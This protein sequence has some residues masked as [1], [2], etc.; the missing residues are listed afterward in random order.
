MFHLTKQNDNCAT[1][2]P[3]PDKA[4]PGEDQLTGRRVMRPTTLNSL[5]I[6][7]HDFCCKKPLLGKSLGSWDFEYYLPILLGSVIP[8]KELIFLHCKTWC[9]FLLTCYVHRRAQTILANLTILSP[10]IW[11][12]LCNFFFFKQSH[13]ICILNGVT[14]SLHTFVPTKL[15]SKKWN[16]MP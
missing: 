2:L 9:Q 12:S 3:K 1:I 6:I 14:L 13:V 11:F 16:F 4:M 10:R 5:L 15:F 7:T 8:I